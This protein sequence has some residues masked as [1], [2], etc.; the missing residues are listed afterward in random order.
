MKICSFQVAFISPISKEA[1]VDALAKATVWGL[2]DRK[3]GVLLS[4][5]KMRDTLLARVDEAITQ[6]QKTT[7]EQWI[8]VTERAAMNH[9]L[10]ASSLLWESGLTR[11]GTKINMHPRLRTDWK[12]RMV[13]E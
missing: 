10:L 3:K 8:P 6:G 5:T 11:R 7:L 2:S 13:W 12:Y 1:V 4:L 9:R